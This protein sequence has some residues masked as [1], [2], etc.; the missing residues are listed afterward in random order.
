MKSQVGCRRGFPRRRAKWNAS[1]KTASVVTSGSLDPSYAC[2]HRSCQRSPASTI[3]TRALVSIRPLG[4]AFERTETGTVF[5][6]QDLPH[7]LADTLVRC[8]RPTY[9]DG[10]NCPPCARV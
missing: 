7:D 3:A 2:R 6:L 5:L 8:G 10:T 4:R 9:R 1:V